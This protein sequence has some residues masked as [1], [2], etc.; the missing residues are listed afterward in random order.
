MEELLK[1]EQLNFYYGE[2]YPGLIDVSATFGVRER[3][4]V[5]GGNGAGKSTFFLCCNGVL[6]PQSG[7]IFLKGR[8]ITHAKKD[9]LLLHQAVGLVF[10]EPDSQIIAAT[11]ESEVSFGPMNLRL[12]REEVRRRVNHSLCQMN[13]EGYQN[14]APQYLSGGE[15]KRVSIADILAME[16][17]IILF[18]EPT[19]SLDP[20][21]IV[22]LEHTLDELSLAGITLV[23]STHDVD[24]AYRFAS[25]AIIFSQGKVIADAA[26]DEVFA[27]EDTLIQ[28]G[29]CKPS[30]YAAAEALEKR[31]AL[32]TSI[33]KPRNSEEFQAY[34]SRLK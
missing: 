2:H 21:N 10:Q 33:R 5:L 22:V 12:D 34:V 4:A 11:V 24:F 1:L 26:I 6:R 29:L 28:A 17:D 14:R 20:E 31:F 27:S 19:A 15:K 30:F 13:L 32:D 8:P 9:I 16:P 25:R 23:V 7:R 18:D 3:V